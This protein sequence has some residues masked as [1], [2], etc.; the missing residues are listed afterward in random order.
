MIQFCHLWA[1]DKEER[2]GGDLVIHESQE[3]ETQGIQHPSVHF[4]EHLHGLTSFHWV[5]SSERSYQTHKAPQS[6]NKTFSIRAFGQDLRT[7]PQFLLK[8]M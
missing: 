5:S 4:K 3:A 2:H 6:G 1:K 8:M 7:K